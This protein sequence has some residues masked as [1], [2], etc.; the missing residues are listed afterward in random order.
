MQQM[1]RQMHE[2]VLLH[3]PLLTHTHTC[4]KVDDTS[5]GALVQGQTLVA[6]TRNHLY[7]HETA[8]CAAAFE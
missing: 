4:R 7:V 8:L 2:L 1:F 3:D 6:L 5:P